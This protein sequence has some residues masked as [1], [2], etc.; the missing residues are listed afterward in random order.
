M[1]IALIIAYWKKAN[2]WQ[3]RN[4]SK[5]AR[6]ELSAYSYMYNNA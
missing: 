3:D 1:N 2:T 6:Q 5:E 4:V